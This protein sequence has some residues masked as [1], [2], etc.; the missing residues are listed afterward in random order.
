MTENRKYNNFEPEQKNVVFLLENVTINVNMAL[1][2]KLEQAAFELGQA[3]ALVAEKQTEYDRLF[4]LVASGAKSARVPK[5][6]EKAKVESTLPTTAH[7]G[8][9][10]TVTEQIEHLLQSDPQK[11]FSYKDVLVKLPIVKKGSVAALLFRLQR[12]GKA[13]KV[14]RGLW[15]TAHPN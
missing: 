5:S 2:Q 15:K 12:D 11:E 4:K 7:N 14:G 8:N 6:T 10:G 9:S 1:K 3:K 13:K